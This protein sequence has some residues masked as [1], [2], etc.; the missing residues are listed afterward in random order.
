MLATGS[1]NVQIALPAFKVFFI[2]YHRHR[3]TQPSEKLLVV[4][5]ANYLARLV[6]DVI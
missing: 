4:A 1:A 2:G 3:V 5:D 6:V